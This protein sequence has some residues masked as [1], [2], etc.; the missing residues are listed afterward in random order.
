MLDRTS[1]KICRPSQRFDGSILEILSQVS[2]IR[3]KPHHVCIWQ[4]RYTKVWHDTSKTEY[5]WENAHKKYN[6]LEARRVAALRAIWKLKDE[7]GDN[8][9][10]QV[11][12]VVLPKPVEK[13]IDAFEMVKDKDSDGYVLT[14]DLRVVKTDTHVDSTFA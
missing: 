13:K 2:V 4:T 14:I 3:T 12:R 6:V 10:S 9:S 7:K 11:H 8:L 1:I 5:E